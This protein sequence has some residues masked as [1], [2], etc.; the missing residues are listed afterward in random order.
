[1][2]WNW[3]VKLMNDQIRFELRQTKN[4]KWGGYVKSISKL[5]FVC[6]F[7]VRSISI[8]VSDNSYHFNLS[9]SLRQK[10]CHTVSDDLQFVIVHHSIIEQ[11]SMNIFKVI[12]HLIIHNLLFSILN[13]SKIQ[14]GYFQ[15]NDSLWQT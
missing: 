6:H 12:C 3:G 15:L 14:T 2:L 9:K 11:C 8:L 10:L 5:D 7:R 1:M 13:F 4:E